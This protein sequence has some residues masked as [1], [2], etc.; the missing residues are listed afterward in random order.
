MIIF[1]G[2]RN[3]GTND[4]IPNIDI[5]LLQIKSDTFKN[6]SFFQGNG[7]KVYAHNIASL[8]RMCC[9]YYWMRI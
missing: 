3:L 1:T 4:V 9:F 2:S 7:F 8:K 6:W 5:S